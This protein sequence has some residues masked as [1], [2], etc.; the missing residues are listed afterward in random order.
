[1]LLAAAATA[2]EFSLSFWLASYLY[3]DV[4][5]P[6][7][8][9]VVAVSGLYL[10][11]LIGRLLASRL[12]RHAGAERVLGAALLTVSVGLPFLLAADD[13][14]IAAIG[15]AITG[16]GI[17]P[18]FPLASSLHIQISGLDAD[19]ALG[20]TLATTSIGQ[21][22]GPLA[23]GVVAQ[24]TSLRAGLF[25]LPVLTLCRRPARDRGPDDEA[26]DGGSPEVRK[27][28]RS[29]PFCLFS[30][31]YP[32][33]P[34]KKAP[35]GRKWQLQPTSRSILQPAARTG[36]RRERRR[37]GAGGGR[38]W[39]GAGRTTAG[40]PRNG[41]AR[42]ERRFAP[43]GDRRVLEPKGNQRRPGPL[44]DRPC[45]REIVKGPIGIDFSGSFEINGDLYLQPLRHGK[46]AFL[47]GD[48]PLKPQELNPFID[49]SARQRPDLPGDAPALLRP[50]ADVLVHPLPRPRP[51]ARAGAGRPRRRW[52][53]RRSLPSEA[54]EEP[55]HAVDARRLGKILH[56]QRE[57]RGRRGRHRR[58]LPQA[59]LAIARVE[60]NPDA[61]ISTGVQFKPHGKGKNGRGRR[62][63]LRRDGLR[64]DPGDRGLMRGSGWQVHCLYN[65]ETDRV[66][67]ALL[68][69]HAEDRRCLRARRGGPQGARPDRLRLRT[70]GAPRRG[71]PAQPLTSGGDSIAG[72][73][74][75][76]HGSMSGC[77]SRARPATQ[78]AEAT[79]A[80]TRAIPK[81]TQTADSIPDVGVA[82]TV[83]DMCRSSG[84]ARKAA[85]PR[86]SSIRAK[87]RG[88]SGRAG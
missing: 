84:P 71:R 55:D 66:T 60:V 4:G 48:V 17:G 36:H 44:L 59:P 68:L 33:T 86:S 5:F 43:E 76:S 28:S 14:A 15:I 45:R 29:G 37:G 58:R 20:Q 50:D 53:R 54:A 67:T 18:T 56:G 23:V 12:V 1:M 40:S 51:T 31:G 87:T 22:L 75:A 62:A 26:V 49:G 78:I 6:R 34:D 25:I 2:L 64:G 61:N 83:S 80:P 41:V 38:R 74:P 77:W 42:A 73:S 88:S 7:G 13:A 70:R 39:P 27:L 8:A 81:A 32:P 72:L 9:A 82:P 52:G 30:Q 10:A 63:G 16:A 69:P 21:V 85:T 24:A 57:R 47:N 35:G 19:H 65:Q 11:S 79:T 3:D 46:Q